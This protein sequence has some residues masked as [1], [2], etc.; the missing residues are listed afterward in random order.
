MLLKMILISFFVWL[1]NVPY[2]FLGGSVGK[3]LPLKEDLRD[4][5]LGNE[6]PLEKKR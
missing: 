6:D 1:R 3:N 2:V 4:Q 5:N